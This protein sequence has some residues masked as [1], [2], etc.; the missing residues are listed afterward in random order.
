MPNFHTFEISDFELQNGVTLPVAK[1]AYKHYGS[2]N[3]DGT[4]LILYP[5]SYGA[6][7]YD[8]DWL[9]GSD[10]VLDPSRYCIVIVNMFGNGLSSS[11]SNLP[12]PLAGRVD[13]FTHVDN[14][15]AQQQLLENVFGVQRPALIYGWSMG[16]QQAFH[17]G[18]LYPD[19]VSKIAALCGTAKTSPHNLV[20][21]EGIRSA[22]CADAAWSGDRFTAKPERGLRAMARVYAGWALSQAFYREHV[23]R[24]LGFESLEDYLIRDWETPFLRRDASNLLSMIE[25]WKRCDISENDRFHGDL[26]AALGAIQA[27]TLVMPGSH[28]MY[29]TPEDIESQAGRIPR[30][31]YR[32]IR[33]IWGHRAGNPAKNPT[34]E[35][36]IAAAVRELLEQ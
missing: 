10:R 14:I 2:L 31:I 26:D 4:N 13:L 12:E 36:F 35:K 8:I 17:W 18:A 33:S 24:K 5:T 9:I 27:L 6:T 22:L 19:R 1:V 30:A 11:P 34:D 7:H 25:T 16:A 23:Y 20:F 29:F 21:L 15:R 28:D 3:A 32:P